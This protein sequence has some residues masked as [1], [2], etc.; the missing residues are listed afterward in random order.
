M[1]IPFVFVVVVVVESEMRDTCGLDH[2]QRELACNASAARYR[3]AA[4]AAEV[5]P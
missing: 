2:S 1:A 5:V 3:Y 4:S